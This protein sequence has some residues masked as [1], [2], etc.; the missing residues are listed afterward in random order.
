[1]KT[2]KPV[3]RTL[4]LIAA[5]VLMAGCEQATDTGTGVAPGLGPFEGLWNET[6]WNGRGYVVLVR[7]TLYVTGH[8]RPV[9][10][11]FYDERVTVTVPFTGAGT[12][13]L[14]GAEAELWEIT[15]GDAGYFARVAGEMVI[16][17]IDWASMEIEGHL[18]LRGNGYD[19]AWSLTAAEF[20]LP[21]YSSFNATPR[22]Y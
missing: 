22:L 1:M 17:R 11:T 7:D 8:H 12:Y 9:A 14:S 5:I 10:R 2:Y 15:G 19:R 4:S 18:E 6:S 16:T 21:I 20:K 13:H 3:T